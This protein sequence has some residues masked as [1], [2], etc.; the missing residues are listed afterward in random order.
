MGLFVRQK[1]DQNGEQASARS[2]TWFKTRLVDI[3]LCF[4]YVMILYVC[5]SRQDATE[6]G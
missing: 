2:R 6:V 1:T 3:C 5:V 4:E